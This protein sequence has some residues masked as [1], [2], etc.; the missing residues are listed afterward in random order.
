MKIRRNFSA[1]A[2]SDFLIC[3]LLLAAVVSCPAC[4][5]YQKLSADYDTYS[6]PDIVS[7]PI[8][9]MLKSVEDSQADADFRNQK[10]RFEEM[11]HR[12]EDA[13]K[14]SAADTRFFSPAPDRLSVLEPAGRDAAAAVRA[15]TSGFT[16]ETLEI[17]ALLRNQGVISAEKTFR[18]KLQAYSQVAN[19][20]EMLRQYS[21]FTQAVMTGV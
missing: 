6:P 1:S 21:A 3:A 12:W 7:P 9:P 13:L 20:D 16:L 14:S 11:S 10:T 15:L 5:H 17:L 8:S 2:L 4:S 19:L 18:S